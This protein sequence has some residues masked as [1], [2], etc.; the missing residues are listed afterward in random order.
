MIDL[1]PAYEDAYSELVDDVNVADVSD[2]DL[3]ILK[4]TLNRDS[5]I[6]ICSRYVNC[7]L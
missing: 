6:V 5:E 2:E 1:T 3:E 7:E 4:L